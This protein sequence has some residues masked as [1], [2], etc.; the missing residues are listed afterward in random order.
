MYLTNL[1]TGFYGQTPNF[2]I[3]KKIFLK[4]TFQKIYKIKSI[5]KTVCK[6]FKIYWVTWHRSLSADI[7]GSNFYSPC[8][9]NINEK[10]D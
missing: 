7:N 6:L 2:T 3:L 8:H 5:I 1:F 9:A 4:V 10:N